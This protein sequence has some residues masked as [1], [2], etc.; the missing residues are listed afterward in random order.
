MPPNP[1]QSIFDYIGWVWVGGGVPYADAADVNF[2]GAM[3]LHALALL[4]FG[5]HLWSFRL[6]DYLGLLGFVAVVGAF[7]SRRQGRAVALVFV[8]LYQ[9]MYVVS[10]YWVAGQRDF[11][12]AHL[13]L[14]SGL[15]F[16]RRS[17][18]DGPRGAS[19]R[20]PDRGGAAHQADVPGVPTGPPGHRRRAAECSGRGWGRMLADQAV[21]SLTLVALVGLTLACGWM[22]GALDDWYD[23]SILYV[24][25]TVRHDAGFASVVHKLACSC[26]H[27]WNWYAAYALAGGILWW[28]HGDRPTLLVV[29]GVL[30]TTLVSAAYQRKGFD[31]HFGG[32]LPVLGIL[33]A[34]FLA[35]LAAFAPTPASGPRHAWPLPWRS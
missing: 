33:A 31:Y 12:A 24:S 26:V 17:R 23:V 9:A 32:I 13:V 25:E 21:V 1:D 14:V 28:R 4:V 7:L 20:V 6:F 5:N 34:N 18:G 35:H 30:A 8:P 10:G 19:P 11:L 27:S 15:L 2:P 16:V 3:A 22:S 29:L